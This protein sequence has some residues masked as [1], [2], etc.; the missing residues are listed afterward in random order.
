MSPRFAVWESICRGGTAHFG[1][2]HCCVGLKVE[3]FIASA[4]SE[5]IFIRPL[6][7]RTH[8]CHIENASRPLRGWG[9]RAG[10]GESPSMIIG[11]VVAS[12]FGLAGARRVFVVFPSIP[13]TCVLLPAGARPGAALWHAPARLPGKIGPPAVWP[14]WFTDRANDNRIIVVRSGK[15]DGYAYVAHLARIRQDRAGGSRMSRR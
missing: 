1:L 9:E 6:S 3:L 7:P 12:E 10:R 8:W 4:L 14:P 13:L 5:S 15:P 11:N 2:L